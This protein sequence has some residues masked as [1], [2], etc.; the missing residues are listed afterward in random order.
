LRPPAFA[1]AGRW[2]RGNLHTHSDRSDGVVPP[3]RVLADYRAAGYDFLVLTDHFEARWGWSITDTGAARDDGFT[4]LLGAEL[5]SADWD[6]EDVFWVNAIGLPADFA[7]PAS[8]DEHADA[9]RRAAEAGA[10]NVLLHPGLTNLMAFDALPVEHLHAVETYNHNAALSWPDQAEARYALDALL[11]RG[12]R[13]HVIAGDDAHFEHPWD[14][15]GAWV[16]VRAERLDSA[17]ILSALKA[18]AYYSTQGPRIDDVRVE[19]GRVY[20]ACSP[21]RAV[22]LTGIHGWRSDVAIAEELTEATLDLGR[23][24]SPF[25]RLTVTDAAGRR[26]WTNPVWSTRP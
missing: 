6:D 20:V 21:A 16:E 26:A 23:L 17:A 10:Y 7:A 1:S 18:G 24:R 8:P 11:A 13:L 4:T 3:E 2:L 19:D 15:F 9:I 25:W 14:R 12:H 22:A 5:S